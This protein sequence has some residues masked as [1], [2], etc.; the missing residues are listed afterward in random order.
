[1]T[2]ET[3]KFGPS[4][5]EDAS[6]SLM[7]SRISSRML[8]TPITAFL[9]PVELA[10]HQTFTSIPYFTGFKFYH[11]TEIEQS[12]PLYGA[13]GFT[14]LN[15]DIKEDHSYAFF[16][17]LGDRISPQLLARIVKVLNANGFHTALAYNKMLFGIKT[18]A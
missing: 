4:A 16:P 5:E 1:M 7:S 6:L 3:T 14:M 2:T 13:V 10:K 9:N 8:E 15:M 18:P 12:E 11:E 17:N